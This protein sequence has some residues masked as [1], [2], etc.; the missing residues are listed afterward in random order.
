MNAVNLR[1]YF[2]LILSTVFLP[3]IFTISVGILILVFYREAWDVAF[4]VLLLCFATA[5]LVGASITVFLLRRTARL[6][7]LQSD[8]VANIS[9]DFRTPLTSIRMFVD[10]LR[11]GKVTAPEEK[12]RC[13]EL[14]AQETERMEALVN[15]VLTWRTVERHGGGGGY[16]PSR[17][18]PGALLDKALGPFRI[19]PEQAARIQ[20]AR[21]PDLHPIEADENALV[22]ALRNL[23]ENALR[24]AGDGPVEITVRGEEQEIVFSVGDQGTPIPAKDRRR[25]FKQFYRAASNRK[26]GTGLGLAIVRHVALSHGGNVDV[27]SSEE[28]GNVFT[29]RLPKAAATGE[30]GEEESQ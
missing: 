19:D 18:D 28:A 26:P 23:V 13:L 5:A 1:A 27:T 3:A 14:L 16:R 11:A 25:I 7:Q 15:R 6:A 2:W 8:F 20:V 12:E 9:H 17:Q 10:T 21:E 22:E 30:G 29:L 4:G 24:Y